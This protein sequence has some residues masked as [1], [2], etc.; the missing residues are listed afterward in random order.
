MIVAPFSVMQ[1][2]MRILYVGKLIEGDNGPERLNHLRRLGYETIG[3]DTSPYFRSGNRLIQSLIWRHQ[4]GSKVVSLNADLL[5]FAESVEYDLI[6]VDKGVLLYPSTLRKLKQNGSKLAVHFTADSQFI[7]NRS[8]HFF[9]SIELYDILVTTKPF[10]VQE[11]EECGANTVLLVLQGFGERFEGAD[12]VSPNLEFECDV[13]FVGHCQPSYAR[14]LKRVSHMPINLKIWGPNW[15]RYAKQNSWCVDS[16][17]G[18]GLWGMDY[19]RALRSS[20]VALGLLSKRIPETTTTRTFEIPASGAFMLAERTSE[21]EQLF[22]EGEEAEFFDT[23]EELCDKLSFYLRH[24]QMRNNIARAGRDK[25]L[26]SRYS[27][28]DQFDYV[29]SIAV[30]MRREKIGESFFHAR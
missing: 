26:S 25:C 16:V 21:H 19:P 14:V 24:P 22:K 27:T 10:E 18:N 20:K 29:M 12:K 28:L 13:C 6:W 15:P 3:F 17:M 5:V 8:R 2:D 9:N 4:I 11:Y 23:T 7:D 30:K 1:R